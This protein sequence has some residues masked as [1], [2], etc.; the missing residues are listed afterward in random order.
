[1][2]KAAKNIMKIILRFPFFLFSIIAW[3]I[4]YDF[5]Y[6]AAPEFSSLISDGWYWVPRDILARF[7]QGKNFRTRWPVSPD[8]V[9]GNDISF[10]PDDVSIFQCKG[11]YF[12]TINGTITIGHGCKIADGVALITTN[13]DPQDVSNH[14]PGRDIVLGKECWLGRNVILLPGVI[15][16]DHV[17]VGAGS[18]VTKSFQEGNVIIAGNPARIIRSL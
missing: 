4:F 10:C 12:Q 7:F 6:L 5:K 3:P 13:H 8:C 15:L 16:G 2:K 18:V 1:M 11:G 9:C 14:L 17:V